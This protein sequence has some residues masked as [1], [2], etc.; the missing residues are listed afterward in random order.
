VGW[1]GRLFLGGGTLP[2]AVRAELEAEGLVALEEGLRGSIR[3]ERF[4]M[5]G[6][7][8]HGKVT[9]E[10]L[11]LGISEKRFALY[12]KGG[13]A[14]LID[15]PFTSPGLSNLDVSVEG[16]DRLAMRVDYDRLGEP[17]VSGVITIRAETPNAAG[18][19]EQLRI[20]IERAAPNANPDG[21][22]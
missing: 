15:S 17:N 16:S 19:A 11:G 20:R 2:P 12:C 14:R 9:P 3:Y 4:K 5:P 1:L 7:R 18:I 6:R 22:A 8:F 13:R 10:H 21:S